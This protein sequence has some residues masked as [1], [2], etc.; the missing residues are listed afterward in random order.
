MAGAKRKTRKAK[1]IALTKFTQIKKRKTQRGGGVGA[2][3]ALGM[4]LPMLLNSA[5]T[6]LPGI[7]GKGQQQQQP[8]GGGY[9]P[10]QQRRRRPPPPRWM[11]RD[12][13]YHYY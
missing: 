11:G 6:I 13:E 12:D 9:P 3:M 4:A 10:P 1:T 2:G 5:S 7:F 8:A